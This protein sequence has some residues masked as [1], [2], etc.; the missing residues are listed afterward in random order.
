MVIN[1]NDEIELRALELSDAHDIFTTI[2]SQRAYLGRWLPFVESTK[3]LA[4]TVDFVKSLIFTPNPRSNMVFTIRVRGQFAGLVGF[5]DSDVGNK[6]TEIG[7]WLSEEFQKQGVMTRSVEK[8]FHHAFHEL[9]MNRVQ[10]LCA[11]GNTPSRQIPIRLGFHLEGI[12]KEGELLSDG[13]FTDLEVYRLTRS[14]FLGEAAEG[15]KRTHFVEEI[16]WGNKKE[17]LF[18]MAASLIATTIAKIPDFTGI[19]PD[20]FYPRNLSFVLFPL[21]AV[22][23][24]WKQRLSWKKTLLIGL[25]F[26]GSVL[27]INTLPVDEGSDTLMLACIHMIFFSWSLLGFAFAGNQPGKFDK[28]IGYLR[29]NGDLVVMSTLILIAGAL[30]ALVTLALFRLVDTGAEQFYM[31]YVIP[32]GLSSAAIFATYLVQA[33]PRLVANVSPVIAKIFTPLLLVTLVVYLILVIA[34]DKDPFHNREFLFHFNVLLVGVMAIIHFSIAENSHRAS[35]RWVNL[36]LP[37]LAVVTIIVNV[38]ALAAILFRITEWGVTPNRIVVLGSNILIL[39][40]LLMVTFQLIMS[41]R[42]NRGGE[43]VERFIAGYLPV[44]VVWVAIVTF[45]FPLLF[46]YK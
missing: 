31:R 27:Y 35:N 9:D 38:I 44:Y 20:Y 7:Y 30:F 16:S 32:W 3:E 40:N 42:N 19:D 39:V 8:L 5:K 43:S 46:Q 45:L 13:R 4:D 34:T 12:M 21:L 41:M 25:A 26:A 33:N 23:F 29:Y 17:L 10:I 11:I 24:I 37:A 28:R 36:Q 14:E 1:V 22:Y 2:D 15:S 18:V 6:K